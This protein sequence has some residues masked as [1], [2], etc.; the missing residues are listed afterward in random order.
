MSL[1]KKG[2]GI[3]DHFN[4]LYLYLRHM[5]LDSERDRQ[6]KFAEQSDMNL[7]H[8]INVLYVVFVIFMTRLG[9]SIFCLGRSTNLD[10]N[11]IKGDLTQRFECV[12]TNRIAYQHTYNQTIRYA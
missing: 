1:P 4:G 5:A 7:H 6:R 3:L 10:D 12:I 2:S 11:I 8:I 9:S